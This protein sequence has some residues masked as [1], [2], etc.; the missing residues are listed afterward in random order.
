V[1][2]QWEWTDSANAGRWGEE[3]EA[4]RLK[5]IYIPDGSDDTFDYSYQVVTTKNRLRGKGRA[6]SL[7]FRSE[8]QKDLQ[9]LGW[10]ADIH[11]NQVV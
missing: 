3:F 10:S 7:K 5:Q 8:P 9:L 1:Q 6:L 11:S 2:S 4:Y